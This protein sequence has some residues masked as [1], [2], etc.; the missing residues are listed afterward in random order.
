MVFSQAVFE[1]VVDLRGTYEALRRW[2]KPGGVM[3]HQIDFK[4]HGTAKRWDGHWA[5]SDFI[6]KLL[7]RRQA[8]PP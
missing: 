2:L 5:Y 6:W 3:S 8:V 1:H 4:A 7:V